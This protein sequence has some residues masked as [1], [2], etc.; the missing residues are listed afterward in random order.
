MTDAL[1]VALVTEVFHEPDGADRLERRLREARKRGARLAVLPELPLNRWCP[2]TREPSEE[3]AEGPSGFRQAAQ[4]RAASRAGLFL[5]GGAIVRDPDSGRRHNTALLWDPSGT[6]VASYRKLH[7]PSEEGFWESDHYEP[8]VE[9]PEV[10][11]VEGFPLGIQICS[12]VN[13]PQVTQVLGA[14]GA[15]AVVAPRATPPE[16]YRRWRLVLRANAVTS[17]LWVVSVNRSGPEPGTSIGG[18][19]LVVAPDGQVVAET[20]DPL[21]VVHL[22]REAVEEARRTYP[23]YLAIRGELYRLGWER[24]MDRSTV[25]SF[26]PRGEPPPSGDPPSRESGTPSGGS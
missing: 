12:D 17:G 19:S 7:L 13:R 10:E 26:E 21:S 6:V 20:T 5:M 25:C 8:G 16:T 23:G 9:L 1:V 14:L 4:A 15:R 24:V 18:P 11:S 22:Q 3:D 2:S